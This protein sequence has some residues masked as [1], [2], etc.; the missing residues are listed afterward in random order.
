MSYCVTHEHYLSCTL[1]FN[2][3]LVSFIFATIFIFVRLVSLFKATVTSQG[4]K[5]KTFFPG[6]NL[7][8]LSESWNVYHL[9]FWN[10][11][12]VALFRHVFLKRFIDIFLVIYNVFKSFWPTFFYRRYQTILNHLLP[13]DQTLLP[14]LALA[15]GN[16][17]FYPNG[18]SNANHFKLF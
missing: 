17:L 9:V 11:L 7:N 14:S 12:K 8:W 5:I 10:Q 4:M 13:Y 1:Q 18:F 15:T 16:L 6:A 3:R 2:F